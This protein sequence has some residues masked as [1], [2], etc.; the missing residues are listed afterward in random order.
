MSLDN[1]QSDS[2]DPDSI[3]CPTSVSSGT[4]SEFFHSPVSAIVRLN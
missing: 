2:A 1:D 3:S 4:T